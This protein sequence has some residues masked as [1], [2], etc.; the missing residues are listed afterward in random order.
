MKGLLI[1][2]VLPGGIADELELLPGDRLLAI[3][4]HKLRDI[5]DY[6][7]YSAEDELLLDILKA[8]GDEWEVEVELGHE[9]SLGLYFVA[10][11]PA[12]CGNKC[13][14]CFV[15]QLPKGLRAPLYVKD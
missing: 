14:F 11:V 5:I 2:S 9:E 8:D 7:F 3:N 4:G 13:V 10:P 6:Q 12:Q 1:E 15:H